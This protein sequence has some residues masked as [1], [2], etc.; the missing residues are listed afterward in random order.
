[1]VFPLSLSTVCGWK[2]RETNQPR[3]RREGA[4]ERE[5]DYVLVNRDPDQ[6]ISPQRKLASR[7]SRESRDART[8]RREWVT[9]T[10][11]ARRKRPCCHVKRA[12]RRPLCAPQGNL[13]RRSA[14]A[15]SSLD[16]VISSLGPLV[17]CNACAQN[18]R[19]KRA[20]RTTILP[21]LRATGVFVFVYLFLFL[22]CCRIHPDPSLSRSIA[23][24]R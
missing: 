2:E 4:L 7:D 23:C 17:A 18:V 1:M 14:A 21:R 19:G 16:F 24:C 20:S 8:T 9:D 11:L 13:Y 22:H 3:N 15:R 6:L 10:G 12:K 5:Q